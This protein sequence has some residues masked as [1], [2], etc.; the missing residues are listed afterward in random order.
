[1]TKQGYK[2][3]YV[4]CVKTMTHKFHSDKIYLPELTKN[5]N[6]FQ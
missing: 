2:N 6:A 3:E 4:W 5:K 1:M